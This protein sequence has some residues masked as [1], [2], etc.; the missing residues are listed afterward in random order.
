M[1]QIN[2]LFFNKLQLYAQYH[3]TWNITTE[4]KTFQKQVQAI[5][6]NISLW[7]K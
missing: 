4:Q 3:T 1:Q 2:I 7:K 6:E 5:A